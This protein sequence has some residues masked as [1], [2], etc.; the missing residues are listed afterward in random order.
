M[1]LKLIQLDIKK[2][3]TQSNLSR[4]DE[5]LGSGKGSGLIVLPEMFH[6]GFTADTAQ[7]AERDGGRPLAWMLDTAR[8]TGYHITGSV[9]AESNGLVYN[10]L[11]IV[12]PSGNIE[13]YDKRHLFSMG[14]ETQTFAAGRE[15][16][17]VNVGDWR[18]LLQVCY[19]VRFPVFSRN[20]GEVYDMAIYVA[21][22]P[23]PR[24]DVWLTLLK[25]R[26]I[27][28][29]CYVVGVNRTG[30]C[31]GIKY[32][33]Q[34]IV[35]GPRGEVVAQADGEGEQVV[36]AEVQLESMQHF[37]QKFPVLRDADKYVLSNQ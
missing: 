34:S 3:D 23:A 17:I 33:G 30:E 14:M 19:D 21:N 29:Q 4:I 10:R 18:C 11:Y 31:E 8:R 7:C 2:D 25:A 15:R 32:K 9:A 1:Q 22:W 27:E 6:C 5:L 13:Y 24:A 35:Y 36:E 20:A 12:S 37:R 28:N 16:K 26:A